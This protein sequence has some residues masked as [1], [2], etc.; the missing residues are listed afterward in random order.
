MTRFGFIG[1][2]KICYWGLI[3]VMWVKPL[4][5]WQYKNDSE[6]SPNPIIPAVHGMIELGFTARSANGKNVLRIAPSMK[7]KDAQYDIVH[8][9]SK[10]FGG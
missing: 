8:V 5:V 2:Q 7:D 1:T 3:G 4:P 9:R 6:E 10:S